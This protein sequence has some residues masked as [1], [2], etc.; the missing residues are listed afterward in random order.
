M[1]KQEILEKLIIA[2]E[3]YNKAVVY[4]QNNM[5][6]RKYLESKFMDAGFCHY[7]M[8][9]DYIMTE[10]ENEKFVQTKSLLWYSVIYKNYSVDDIIVKVLRPR[11][12]HLERTIAR[13]EKELAAEH[14]NQTTL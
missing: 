12:K 7:F 1:S 8:H 6:L 13:L 3:E 14:N 9:N 10:L 2:L 11:I 4:G 5:G